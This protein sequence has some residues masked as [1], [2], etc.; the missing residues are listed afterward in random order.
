VQ[1]IRASGTFCEARSDNDILFVFPMP[2]GADIRLGHLL[3]LDPTKI[4]SS[5]TIRNVTTGQE[6]SVVLKDNDV[7]DLRLP[8]AHGSS[9]FP[10]KDRLGGA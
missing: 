2:P 10:S 6:F 1:S 8:M 5:Q 3:E 9:R 4:N 7:H